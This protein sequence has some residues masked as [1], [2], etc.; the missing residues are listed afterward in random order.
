MTQALS[1]S[2]DVASFSKIVPLSDLE[3]IR[4]EN[5]DLTIVHCHGVFDVFHHGHLEYLQSAKDM[6]D[7]LV[8]T[9]TSDRWVNKGPSRPYHNHTQ[10]AEII[11]NLSFVDCVAISDENSAIKAIYTLK[12]DLYV[13]GKDYENKEDDITGAILKEEKAAEAHGGK[14]AFTQTGLKSS[15]RIINAHLTNWNGDASRVIKSI[16]ENRS[17]DDIVNIVNSFADMKVLVVGEPIIDTYTFCQSEALSSKSPTVSARFIKEENYAGGSLAIANHLANLGCKVDLCTAFG[18]EEYVRDIL[19]DSMHE[20]VQISPY[21]IPDTPTPRKTRF[22]QRG[23]NQKIFEITNISN[24]PWANH[25]SSDFCEQLKQHA[26][27]ADVVICADFG[28]GMIEGSVLSVLKELNAFVATNVQTNSSNLGFNLFTKH[29]DYNFLSID[30]RELRLGLHD[31][32]SPISKLLDNAMDNISKPFAITL[33]VDGSVYVDESGEQ[34]KCPVFFKEVV[35]TTGAGD[36]FFLITSLLAQKK[37]DGELIS[38]M[39]NCYAWLATQVIG[40]K[41]ANSTVD[42]IRTMK[43]ILG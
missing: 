18:D 38:F 16:R 5:C 11:A 6:G 4:T 3:K 22:V 20:N 28:H 19:K 37:V 21:I 39:G 31:R 43:S 30:E 34:H 14:L 41:E 15:T 33:G 26:L 27:G 42:Y 1:P 29:N 10:R 40:N 35:D 2:E 9:V 8:V 17:L 12:P 13:K 36:A 32:S 25:N 24:D 7:F 23:L